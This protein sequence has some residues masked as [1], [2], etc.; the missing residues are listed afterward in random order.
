ML[1]ILPLFQ[2]Q[3]HKNQMYLLSHVKLT[4]T[5]AFALEK[6]EFHMVQPSKM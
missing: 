3:N 1:K 5:I 6:Q 2:A 4:I